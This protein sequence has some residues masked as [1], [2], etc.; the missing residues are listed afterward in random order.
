MFE[1]WLKCN[2]FQGIFSDE[3]GVQVLPKQGEMSA[4]IVS[5][6]SVQG[7][8]N[9]AGKVRVKVYREGNTSWAVLPTENR[10]IIPVNDAD[11]ISA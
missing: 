4:F 3:I 10:T 5:R 8:F 7:N 2:V 11:L 9:Q 6:D 1:T